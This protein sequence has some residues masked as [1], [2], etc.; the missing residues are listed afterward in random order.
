[1]KRNV[2]VVLDIMPIAELKVNYAKLLCYENKYKRVNK[3]N[4]KSE[5]I[6]GNRDEIE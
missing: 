3:F 2:Y 6:R 4:Y 5:K 1:M